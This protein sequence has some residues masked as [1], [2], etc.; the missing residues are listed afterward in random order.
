MGT[1][2]RAAILVWDE[3]VSNTLVILLAGVTRPYCG[4]RQARSLWFVLFT[5]NKGIL[6]RLLLYVLINIDG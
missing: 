3:L 6:F 5:A 2:V 1:K 4:F